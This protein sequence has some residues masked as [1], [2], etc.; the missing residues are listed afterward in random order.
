MTSL[1]VQVK[2]A[3]KTSRS[4]KQFIFLLGYQQILFPR[5]LRKLVAKSSYHHAWHS[6]YYGG[7]IL[8]ILERFQPRVNVGEHSTTKKPQ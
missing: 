2:T 6:G 1:Y 5:S 3:F 4:I 7:G 8:G